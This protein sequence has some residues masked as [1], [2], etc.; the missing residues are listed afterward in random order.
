MDSP[1]LNTVLSVLPI[2]P[3]LFHPLAVPSFTASS[4]VLVPFSGNPTYFPS[5]ILTFLLP[6]LV[7][8]GKLQCL[9]PMLVLGL[10]CAQFYWL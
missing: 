8:S 5:Y 7:L 4:K 10:S 6:L 2:P 3:L 1:L 9:W